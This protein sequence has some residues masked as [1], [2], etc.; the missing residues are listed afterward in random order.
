MSTPGSRLQPGPANE[1]LVRAV[2]QV[3]NRLVNFL[4]NEL[5]ASL[6]DFALWQLPW[7][8]ANGIN[9]QTNPIYNSPSHHQLC[10]K[11][12]CECPG[13]LVAHEQT[14]SRLRNE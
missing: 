6:I 9:R 7:L 11:G 2:A 8:V 4:R 3:D 14:E 12:D 1:A 5:L 10:D 13:N